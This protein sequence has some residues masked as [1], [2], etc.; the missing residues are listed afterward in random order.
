MSVQRNV[1]FLEQTCYLKFQQYLTLYQLP[2]LT[3][4]INN[5]FMLTIQMPTRI[6]I[7][8]FLLCLMDQF[9]KLIKKTHTGACICQYTHTIWCHNIEKYPKICLHIQVIVRM[10]IA[11]H[12]NSTCWE[13][14]FNFICKLMF[15][16]FLWGIL[17]GVEEKLYWNFV[18][19]SIRFQFIELSVN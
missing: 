17:L 18:K 10:C 9:R 11:Y 5:R 1:E 2:E 3:D 4:H 12:I 13:A 8:N 6:R 7:S 14:P 19:Y 15:V 16:R